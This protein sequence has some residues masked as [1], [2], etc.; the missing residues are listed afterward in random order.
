MT[1]VAYPQIRGI[2]TAG[3]SDAEVYREVQERMRREIELTE[4][5]AEAAYA[6][7]MAERLAGPEAAA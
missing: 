7:E 3:K 6:A 4:R 2:D 1:N 5:D